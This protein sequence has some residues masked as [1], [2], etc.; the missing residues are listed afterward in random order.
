M[1][2]SF[3]V[4]HPRIDGPRNVPRGTQGYLG[5]VG[6]IRKDLT[7]CF[8]CQPKAAAKTYAVCTI[9]NTPDLPIHCVVWAKHM[10]HALFGPKDDGNPL[11]DFQLNGMRR[12]EASS[13]FIDLI[14]CTH[15]L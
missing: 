6:A 15:W 5:Q 12:L 2:P 4:F 7:E 10:A 14:R 8:E 3:V 11:A 9:R 1:H 13:Y